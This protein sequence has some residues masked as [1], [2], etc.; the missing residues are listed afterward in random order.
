[1]LEAPLANPLTFDDVNVAVVVAGDA[2]VGRDG[3]LSGM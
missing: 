1:M 3:F 2:A